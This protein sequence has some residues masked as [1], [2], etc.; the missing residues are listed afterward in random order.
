TQF[1]PKSQN[2]RAMWLGEPPQTWEGGPSRHVPGTGND[3]M[4]MFWRWTD[5]CSKL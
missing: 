5:C 4:Y 2:S 3:A 1:W